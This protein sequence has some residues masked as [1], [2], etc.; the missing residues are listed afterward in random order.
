[1]RL[2]KPYN[3]A[4]LRQSVSSAR[5]ALQCSAAIAPEWR[6]GPT[7]PRRASSANC[8]ASAIWLR[9]IDRILFFEDNQ[10][11]GFV[12]SRIAPRIVEQQS[13]S[14]PVTSSGGSASSR[15]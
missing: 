14:S 3:A 7:S 5:L 15:S 13:A 2:S 11:S 4:I 9:F 1:M 6:S 10:V 8:R 12:Q